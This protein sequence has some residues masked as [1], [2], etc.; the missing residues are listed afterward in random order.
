MSPACPIPSHSRPSAKLPSA[1]DSS[2]ASL[3]T[4]P[5]SDPLSLPP[6]VVSAAAPHPIPFGVEIRLHAHAELSLPPQMQPQ[7]ERGELWIAGVTRASV[8]VHLLHTS[9]DPRESSN[10]HGNR[11]SC[12]VFAQR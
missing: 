3:L 4:A 8:R 5:W 10:I 11:A 6:T 9:H 2:L 12:A 7:F 1:V